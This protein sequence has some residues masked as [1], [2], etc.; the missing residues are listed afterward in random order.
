VQ[1]AESRIQFKLIDVRISNKFIMEKVREEILERHPETRWEPKHPYVTEF[2]QCKRGKQAAFPPRVRDRVGHLHTSLLECQ[3]G[4]E[5]ACIRFEQSPDR[6]SAWSCAL[7]G[8]IGSR[9]MS[10]TYSKPAGGIEI[11]PASCRHQL[12]SAS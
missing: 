9:T 5:R 12:A 4:E 6:P 11:R 7:S 1:S 10:L 3:P 2:V 8:A